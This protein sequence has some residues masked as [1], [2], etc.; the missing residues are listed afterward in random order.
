MFFKAKTATGTR[1]FNVNAVATFTGVTDTQTEIELTNGNKY[2]VE[3]T[4][5]SIRGYVK[6]AAASTA[7]AESTED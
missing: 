3:N 5:R 2:V 6:K 4:E 7:A 1:E